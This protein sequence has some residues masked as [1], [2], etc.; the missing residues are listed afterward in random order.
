MPDRNAVK[1]L[2]LRAHPQQKYFY[3]EIRAFSNEVIKLQKLFRKNPDFA[4]IEETVAGKTWNKSGSFINKCICI[5]EN[6][7]LQHVAEFL[8]FNDYVIRCLAFDGLMIEGDHYNDQALL[9]DINNDV[10]AKFEGL[11]MAFD[12]KSHNNSI[13]IPDDF[14]ID[15][16][17][18]TPEIVGIMDGDDDVTC[19]RSNH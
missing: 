13:V 16:K 11:N 9:T 10:N 3:P 4:E 6:F 15:E 17:V 5:M 18:A 7:I 12:F 2:Y 14:Q 1:L 19:C 8:K